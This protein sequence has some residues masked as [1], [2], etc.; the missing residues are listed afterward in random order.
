MSIEK[1]AVELTVVI[2]EGCHLCEDMV[3]AL[4]SFQGELGFE[5]SFRDVDADPAL[6]E[7]YHT[8]V[9]VLLGPRGKICH[10]FLDL[11]A[12]K[13]ALNQS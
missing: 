5:L 1:A 9:P 7:Q 2:R 12:L 11:V 8:L 4:R 10:Y 13:A 6:R 3:A